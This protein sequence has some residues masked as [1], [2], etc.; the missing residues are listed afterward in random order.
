MR[1][2]QNLMVWKGTG[3]YVRVVPID[4]SILQSTYSFNF[5]TGDLYVFGG[6]RFISLTAISDIEVGFR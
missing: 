3:D 5:G 1:D 4:G 2:M 6:Y